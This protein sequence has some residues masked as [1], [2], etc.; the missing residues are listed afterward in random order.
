[1][2]GAENCFRAE[3]GIRKK[4]EGKLGPEELKYWIFY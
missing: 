2:L 1:V 4:E 3:Y